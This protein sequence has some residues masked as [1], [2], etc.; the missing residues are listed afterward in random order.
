MYIEKLRN[1][2]RNNSRG[3]EN[4]KEVK[5]RFEKIDGK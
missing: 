1:A 4:G 2:V 3:Q 5:I